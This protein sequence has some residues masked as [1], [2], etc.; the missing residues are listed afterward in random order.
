M[1]R[2]IYIQ[3]RYTCRLVHPAYEAPD[4]ADAINTSLDRDQNEVGQVG[5]VKFEARLECQLDKRCFEQGRNAVT[6]I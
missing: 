1:N 6:A 3:A 2:S 4:G 5:R